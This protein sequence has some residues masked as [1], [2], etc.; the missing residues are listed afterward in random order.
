MYDC[1][2]DLQLP[3]TW[4]NPRL[5]DTI[6]CKSFCYPIFFLIS[7]YNFRT[8]NTLNLIRAAIRRPQVGKRRGTKHTALNDAASRTR[9]STLHGILIDNS[10]CKNTSLLLCC[11][12]AGL[13]EECPSDLTTVPSILRIV[14]GTAD[15]TDACN[16][17]TV[18]S[19]ATN[20]AK[21]HVG[22]V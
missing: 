10:S 17:I 3:I 6:S 21:D 1:R 8:H 16:N 13:R 20:S 14:S 22:P 15:T 7:L 4:Q 5:D 2:D 12:N 18:R 19:E 11:M 9:L